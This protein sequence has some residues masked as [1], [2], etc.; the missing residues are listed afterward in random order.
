[1]STHVTL[2][3]FCFLTAVVGTVAEAGLCQEIGGDK[4]DFVYIHCCYVSGG[5]LFFIHFVSDKN[6]KKIF[7]KMTSSFIKSLA[8]LCSFICSRSVAKDSPLAVFLSQKDWIDSEDP[9]KFQLVQNHV[10]YTLYHGQGDTEEVCSANSVDFAC[11]TNATMSL[12]ESAL[13]RC[14]AWKYSPK[15]LSSSQISVT[16]DHKP[17]NSSDM[18]SKQRQQPLPKGHKIH[19]FLAIALVLPKHPFSRPLIDSIR[20]VA[21][22]YPDVLTYFGIANQFHDL[23]N[24]YGVRSYP[25]LLLYHNGMLVEQVRND[26]DRSYDVATL[27]KRFSMLTNSLPRALPELN[28]HRGWHDPDF[29][30]DKLGKDAKNMSTFSFNTLSEMYHI[31]KLHGCCHASILTISEAMMGD[32]IEPI[33]SITTQPAQYEFPVYVL[34]FLYV[35]VRLTLYA[36]SSF[37]TKLLNV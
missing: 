28:H 2:I 6:S 12:F 19:E 8:F 35:L 18:G 23:C 34:S 36:F 24:Q 13:D 25:Q 33:V 9:V 11:Q 21:P 4:N 7:T 10:H 20:I 3:K 32:S 5:F 30:V 29:H 14:A 26:N 22:M 15:I 16:R 31:W 17:R 1:M 37:F 27:A